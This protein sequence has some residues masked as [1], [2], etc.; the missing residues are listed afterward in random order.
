[1]NRLSIQ[2]I[3]KTFTSLHRQ[4]TALHEINLTIKPKEFFVLLGPSGCG[5]STLLNLCAGL[6]HPTHGEILYGD[7]V[8][9]SVNEKRFLSPRERNV[10]MVFQN[11]ALYPHMTVEE[12]IA[13]PLRIRGIDKTIRATMVQDTA[14]MLQLDNLLNAKPAELSGGQRQ[15]VAIARAIVRK[16]DLFLL[17]EPLSNLDAQLR[18]HTRN[19]LKALQKRLGITTIYV[20]HDQV[21]AM[22]L[23]DRIALLN[24]GRIEQIGTPDELYHNPVNPFVAKFI[25][26]PPMNIIPTTIFNENGK[27]LF[28]ISGTK[29]VIPEQPGKKVATA[30]SC[31][32]GIRPEHIM[33]A[34]TIDS[35]YFTV[36]VQGIERMGRETV[37]Y[38]DCDS[39]VISFF[40]TTI[41][42]QSGDTVNITF[43]MSKLHIF[44]T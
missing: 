28:T 26:S 6:E 31:L 25:G 37:I 12:N 30:G 8:Y 11:Y 39:S 16:P 38:A 5:K 29:M 7:S 34:D 18:A 22:T 27:L 19:S 15:R 4:V 43:D 13:F 10:A 42:P 35:K 33:I 44:H 24:H 36:R 41:T 20:T 1:M 21:E 9:V 14:T 3:T 17:D 23:G 40:S 32:I 2:N